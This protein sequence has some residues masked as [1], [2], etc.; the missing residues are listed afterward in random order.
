MAIN[1]TPINTKVVISNKNGGS[2][3]ITEKHDKKGVQY[4]NI[5]TVDK[6]GNQS[7]YI[8]QKPSESCSGLPSYFNVGP[9]ESITSVQ[10]FTP[11]GKQILGFSFNPRTKLLATPAENIFDK[12][13]K[14]RLEDLNY[15]TRNIN[16]NEC[17][18]ITTDFY[19]IFGN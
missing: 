6:D 4:F 18:T 12:G 5:H 10:D 13:N 3:T 7:D 16:L 8:A 17:K 2:R 11:D 15:N 9:G 14:K 1:P 19:T